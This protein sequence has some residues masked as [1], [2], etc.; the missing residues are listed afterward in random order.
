MF[1]VSI[2]PNIRRLCIILV[3]SLL[4]LG[5]T[6]VSVINSSVKAAMV[7]ISPTPTF[8]YVSGH[9][10][11]PSTPFV[12]PPS[13]ASIKWPSQHLLAITYPDGGQFAYSD[14]IEG[15]ANDGMNWYFTQENQIWKLPINYSLNT[16]TNKPDADLGILKTGLP[17]TMSN[18]NGHLG[19]LDYYND[20]LVV[21]IE[22]Y[23]GKRHPMISFFRASDL[24]FLGY[25][26][27]PSQ[28]TAPWV[29]VRHSDTRLYSS[30]RETS[31]LLGYTIDWN[32]VWT[33]Q[34]PKYVPLESSSDWIDQSRLTLVNRYP[35]FEIPILNE[36]NT[37]IM[38]SPLHG[39]EFDYAEHLYLVRG[40]CT[41]VTPDYGIAGFD[42]SKGLAKMMV[43][44]H[45]GGNDFNFEFKPGKTSCLE[46]PGGITFGEVKGAPG[47]VGQMHVIVVD[48]RDNTTY[49]PF[50]FKHYQLNP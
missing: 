28:N 36:V 8:G 9:V 23:D 2:V 30:D 47:I 29:A 34:L 7:V 16:P 11:L 22:F 20:M 37:P 46:E 24:K 5:L 31:K 21:P 19:D 39:G 45:N 50:Y 42:V 10:M 41:G 38:L 32:L 25:I 1:P 44:S 17:A 4:T 26:M 3:T 27:L 18:F 33:D 14:E 49:T 12:L 35:D 48:H 13:T 6:F 40:Q 15:V 43:H